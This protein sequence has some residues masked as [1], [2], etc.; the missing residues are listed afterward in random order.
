MFD[1]SFYFLFSENKILK[2]CIFN[3]FKNITKFLYKILNNKIIFVCLLMNN[4]CK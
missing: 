1:L 2:K 3:Y 4:L